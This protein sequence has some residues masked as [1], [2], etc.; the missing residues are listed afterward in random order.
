[1]MTSVWFLEGNI[2]SGKSTLAQELE[3][4]GYDVLFEPV[5]EWRNG[6]AEGEEGILAKFYK[7]KPKFSLAMQVAATT[8]R[9]RTLVERL[10]AGEVK[11][12]IVERSFFT[13]RHVFA[14]NLLKSEDL[15]DTEWDIFLANSNLIESLCAPTFSRCHFNYI[16]LKTDPAVCNQRCIRRDRSEEF[17]S[18]DAVTPKYLIELHDR[19][20]EWL[21]SEKMVDHVWIVDGNKTPEEILRQTLKIIQ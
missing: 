9:I 7:D 2:S 1:M 6:L 15:S 12:L 8:S 18:P 21:E 3:K 10:R 19:H 4:A 5:E 14:V 11:T 17:V 16:F 20:C 13:D